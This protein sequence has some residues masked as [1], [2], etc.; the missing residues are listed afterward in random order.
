MDPFSKMSV[1][2]LGRWL[3]EQGVLSDVV[4][5]FEGNQSN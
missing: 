5:R 1:E 3:N 2:E 4:T